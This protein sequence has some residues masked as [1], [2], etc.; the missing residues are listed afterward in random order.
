MFKLD[1]VV[2]ISSVVQLREKINDLVNFSLSKFSAVF[3]NF[4]EI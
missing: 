1:Y 4:R 2:K 3:A